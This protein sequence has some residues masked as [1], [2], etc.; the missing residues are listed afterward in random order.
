MLFAVIGIGLAGVEG[1]CNTDAHHPDNGGYYIEGIAGIDNSQRDA[2][3]GKRA[4]NTTW[5]PNT[6]Y[7][8]G[9]LKLCTGRF[10]SEESRVN[11][12]KQYVVAHTCAFLRFSYPSGGTST[13]YKMPDLNVFEACDFTNAQMLADNTQGDPHFDYVIEDDHEK[14]LYYFASK[15]GCD[16]GQ[17]LAVQV[18][19]DYAN[20]ANQCAGMGAGSSRI[21]HC[22]CDHQL[23][24]TTLIDPCHTAFVNACLA[25]MPDDKSCC[26]DPDLVSYDSAA[27]KYLNGGT[28]V[29]KSKEQTMMQMVVDTIELCEANAT[30]CAEYEALATC[31]SAYNPAAYDPKCNQWKAI[32]Q[33]ESAPGSTTS[34]E[35]ECATNLQ[36]LMYVKHRS[37]S[38][39]KEMDGACRGPG[40]VN[41]KVNSKIIHQTPLEDCKK[42]CEEE[43]HCV[44]YAYHPEANG[45]ECLV[46]G[47]GMAGSCSDASA[48]SPDACAA[49]GSCSDSTKTSVD[50]CGTCSEASADSKTACTSVKG[51]WSAATWTS[52]GA[53]WIDPEDP[54]KS[55]YHP[56]VIVK[57]TTLG[58]AGYKCYD[59]DPIDHEAKC[60][61]SDTCVSAFAGKDATEQ[62]ADKCPDGCKFTAAPKA[63]KVTIPHAPII[64]IDGYIHWAGVCRGPG[65]PQSTDAK[66]N[67]KYSKKAGVNG[68]VAT[69]GECAA[70]CTTE[71]KCIAYAH[72]TS[73]CLIYGEGVDATA[74]GEIWNADN[75]P[76]TK[77][78]QTK[79]NPA[80][81]CGLKC[82]GDSGVACPSSIDSTDSTGISDATQAS[83]SVHEQGITILSGALVLVHLAI[84][85]DA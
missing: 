77:V 8:H 1:A 43:A 24:G 46:H 34:T 10:C 63:A 32:K 65:D 56:S 85:H 80:Y 58:S 36:W 53:T 30:K 3:S 5:A 17:K 83:Q 41:D 16:G 18:V 26:P 2:I 29:P 66:P 73:W 71:P 44:A 13:V 27:R 76:N 57:G 15:D 79:A 14:K 75:H 9:E 11:G 82:G 37:S 12:S 33:C 62:I 48:K 35:D 6:Y 7:P 64:D 72:S 69:Q 78:T 50:T 54:W 47:S 20:N 21:Q 42:Y 49:L 4:D 67:G 45:G 40:G 60:T 38:S 52:A 19:D 61:G 81:I 68:G 23:K 28:C 55:D 25:D 51:T 70:A 31:P 59:V 39:H 84:P 74:D 22:D